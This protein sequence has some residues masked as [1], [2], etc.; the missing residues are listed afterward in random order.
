VID[1]EGKVSGIQVLSGDDL[2]V[3]A[4]VDAVLQWRYKPILIESEPTEV[5]TTI[6]ITFS[7]IE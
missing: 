2:L 3:Q 4:A 5:D 6:T 1:K 7:L